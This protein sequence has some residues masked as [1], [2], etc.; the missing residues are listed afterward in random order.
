MVTNRKAGMGAFHDLAYRRL[1][2][3]PREATRFE[4]S[5]ALIEVTAVGLNPW[6]KV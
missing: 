2:C 6:H 5:L 4:V 3:G 1:G